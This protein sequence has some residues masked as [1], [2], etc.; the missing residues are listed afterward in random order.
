MG[1]WGLMG[2]VGGEKGH[3]TSA[4][5]RQ[6]PTAT[7]SKSWNRSWICAQ[8]FTSIAARAD[9]SSICEI[10][11]LRRPSLQKAVNIMG[12]LM[13]GCAHPQIW[14]E[15]R[16]ICLFCA[17]LLAHFLASGVGC[18]ALNRRTRVVW[19]FDGVP[20]RDVALGCV[21]SHID[22]K[23]HYNHGRDSKC[24]IVLHSDSMFSQ[25]KHPCR[26]DLCGAVGVSSGRMWYIS[27]LAMRKAGDEIEI[28]ASDWVRP[29]PPVRFNINW[30]EGILCWEHNQ[31][32]L[33]SKNN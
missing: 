28:H 18:R 15:F 21:Y 23:E 29:G 12:K 7:E 11:L 3:P 22:D 2:L 30:W 8:T 17:G 31:A 14:P 13:F 5:S 27:G 19:G 24:D 1:F 10:S 20:L 26:F 16:R 9:G 25:G 32:V 6:T 33:V 4:S